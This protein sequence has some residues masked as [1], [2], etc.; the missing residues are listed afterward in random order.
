MTGDTSDGGGTTGVHHRRR[1]GS[2]PVHPALPTG[3]E[4]DAAFD[5]LGCEAHPTPLV[6]SEQ[7]SSRHG[8]AVYL[9]LESLSPIRSFKHRGAT[10]AV[11][12]VAA[13]GAPIVTA[14][15]GNHGQGVAHAA[16]RSGLHAT[17]VVP[18]DASPGK[19]AAIEGLGARIVHHGAGLAES[20][21]H[22]SQ[23][24]AEIGGVYIEDGEDPALMA[25]AATIVR[26]IMMQLPEVDGLVVPVGGGNLAAGSLLGAPPALRARIIGVQS[27]AAPAVARSWLAGE[28]VERP[29]ATFAGGLATERPGQLAFAVLSTALDWMGL[30]NEDDL[31][32]AIAAALVEA[33]VVVEGAAAAPFALLEH[34]GADLPGDPLVLVVSGS[35]LSQVEL[36]AALGRRRRLVG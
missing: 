4:I 6:R 3:T 21:R 8:R 32:D 31:L 5:L 14:S 16:R 1:A 23:L 17:V 35:W 25:G 33:G 10:V 20:Q 19:V 28:L 11:G 7:L 15:T 27:N 24:A 12:R 13:G 36:E 29:C 18:Q 30:V 2:A 26:E 22:A 9:K 34:H